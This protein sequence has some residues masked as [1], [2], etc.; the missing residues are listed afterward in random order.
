MLASE[1]GGVERH[2]RAVVGSKRHK[3]V[4][5]RPYRKAHPNKVLSAEQEKRAIQL[6]EHE[7]REGGHVHE[8]AVRAASHADNIY[9]DSGDSAGT[10][11]RVSADGWEVLPAAPARFVRSTRGA[12]LS[13]TLADL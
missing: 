5:S 3:G 8:S 2:I 12:L 6:L 11:F 9:V 7:A 10:V 1:P 13:T 4:V